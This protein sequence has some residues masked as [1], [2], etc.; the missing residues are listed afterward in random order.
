MK[1]LFSLIVATLLVFTANAASISSTFTS[2]DLAVG[3]G[4]MTWTPSRTDFG[5]T[6]YNGDKGAQFG[7]KSNPAGEFALT[8][9]QS[10]EKVQK[11]VANLATSV[12]AKLHC[13]SKSAK[14]QSAKP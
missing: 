12:P 8:A 7:S 3:E 6:G 9:G 10:L 14:P 4:E 13:L 2:K 11:V 1:K 5:Y